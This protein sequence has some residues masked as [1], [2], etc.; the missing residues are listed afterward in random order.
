MRSPLRTS[1]STAE[2]AEATVEG[3]AIEVQGAK[4]NKRAAPGGTARR[5]SARFPN[6]PGT[7][8]S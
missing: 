7:G 4:S 1:A 8:A 3:P 6:A 2:A 5:S